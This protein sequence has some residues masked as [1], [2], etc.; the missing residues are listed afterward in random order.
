M[1]D[2]IE[3][4]N[5]ENRRLNK[6]SEGN[7]SRAAF[8]H[9]TTNEQD[10]KNSMAENIILDL[11]N[12]RQDID[13][14]K[15]TSKTML[16]EMNLIKIALNQIT[17]ALN[18]TVQGTPQNPASATGQGLNMDNLSALGD[19]LQKGS[20]A[21]KNIK[22]NNTGVDDFTQSIVERSKQEAIQSLDIVSLI[23]QKVKKT[24]VN[25]IAGDLAGNFINKQPDKPNSH[26]PQ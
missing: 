4:I 2:D 9:V 19:L 20:E 22:G 1:N 26:D 17:E 11:G 10:S 24:L 3:K 6:P 23:N 18:K 14:L 21:W 25:D 12:Q 5:E 16:D 15:E 7:Q 13:F 8:S